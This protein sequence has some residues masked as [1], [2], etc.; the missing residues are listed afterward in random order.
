MSKKARSRK[1]GFLK[2]K[3]VS[4]NKKVMNM[5]PPQ[6][7]GQINCQVQIISQCIFIISPVH[8][9]NW[10]EAVAVQILMFIYFLPIHDGLER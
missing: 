5:C 7:P 6:F 9:F 10:K 8:F 1:I 4:L 3:K 2:E